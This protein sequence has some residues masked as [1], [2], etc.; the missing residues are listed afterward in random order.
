MLI[1]PTFIAVLQACVNYLT[2]FVALDFKF[3]IRYT[4]FVTGTETVPVTDFIKIGL[5]EDYFI[6]RRDGTDGR[7]ANY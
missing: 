7:K 5:L 4:F 2:P 3:F 6:I 1:L